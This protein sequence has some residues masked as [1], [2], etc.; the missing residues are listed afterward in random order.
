MGWLRIDP[1][2][3]EVGMDISRCVIL[4]LF[5]RKGARGSPLVTKPCRLLAASSIKAL[6]RIHLLVAKAQGIRLR[7]GFSLEGPRQEACR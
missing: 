6:T 3:E 4:V 7:D 1:L 5:L 2:E